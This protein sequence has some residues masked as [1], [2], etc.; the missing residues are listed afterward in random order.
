MFRLDIMILY[1]DFIFFESANLRGLRG[2]NQSKHDQNDYI[3]CFNSSLFR[4][5]AEFN[6]AL[7]C[8]YYFKHNIQYTRCFLPKRIDN[9]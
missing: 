7:S 8:G 9:D 6:F 4:Y 5:L 1:D 2:Q 3:F